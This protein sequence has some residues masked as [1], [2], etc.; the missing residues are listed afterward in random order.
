MQQEE[1]DKN[2]N[3][4]FVKEKMVQ[5]TILS[6]N[7]KDR[8]KWMIGKCEVD[9][10]DE[11]DD[12]KIF[13]LY[14]NIGSIDV[15]LREIFNKFTEFLQ[16][17]ALCGDKQDEL[18]RT[19]RKERQSA[20]DSRNLYYQTLHQ[21]VIDGDIS[22]EKLKN[23]KSVSLEPPKFSG[24]DSKMDIYSFRSDF[25][26]II[27]PNQQKKYWLETLKKKCLSGPA[28]VLVEKTE[29]IEEAWE[30]LVCSYG[31]VKMLLQSKVGGLDK[32]ECL[33][34]IKGDEKIG[35]ALAKIIN[36]MI[37]LS[38]VA[39]KYKLEYKLYVGGG[40]EKVYNLIGNAMERKFLS[41]NLKN[42]D[43]NTSDS[44]FSEKLDWEN[45]LEFL[46]NE[47]ALR[48]KLSLVNKSKVALGLKALVTTDT[49]GNVGNIVLT[50]HICGNSGDH[51]LSSDR[52]GRNYIDYF[53]CRKFVLCSPKERKNE[54]MGKKLC[55]QCLR[56]GQIFNEDHNCIKTYICPDNSHSSHPRALHVLVCEQHKGNP[57]NVS[58]LEK[59][60]KFIIA[61]RGN[62]EDFT[63]NISLT[64]TGCVT[65]SHSAFEGKFV[66]LIP[67]IQV[68]AIFM[69]Q[70]IKVN[71]IKLC[72]FFDS[73][74]GDIVVK[75]SA[76]DLLSKVGRAV[77][78][79]SNPITM[80]GV[81]GKK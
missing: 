53:S 22:E 42:S 73:G 79:V 66:K 80:Y 61:K 7:I 72:L 55:V 5:A 76:I 34:K 67:D 2:A 36:M 26:L 37:D 16:I 56:P 10:F 3:D 78:L 43:K 12:F 38:N 60:K 35:N 20:L 48:E 58:L 64:C 6:E 39:K 69:F 47:H 27:Q 30:K 81:G 40:L 41:K 15:E 63:K 70:S 46:K 54:L 45:L 17:T 4:A 13:D 23:S 25:E 75:K 62:F 19:T 49:H 52:A 71:G 51:V 1:A 65:T 57:A 68:K 14:K 28:L 59:Y 18:V 74:C 29:T 32:L 33:D 9:K 44:D 24:W 50:C 8:A 31:N 77:P 21:K 11:L